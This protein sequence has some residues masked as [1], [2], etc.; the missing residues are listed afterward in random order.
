MLYGDYSLE[1]TASGKLCVAAQTGPYGVVRS[2]ELISYLPLVD[3]TD[4][5]LKFARLKLDLPG[6]I[7]WSDS[8][9]GYPFV[10]DE[11][12]YGRLETEKN[13]EAA[14]EWAR[15][16]G[17]LGLTAGRP[18]RRGGD[19]PRIGGNPMG[20]EEDTVWR[21][22][23]ESF[24][25]S[26]TLRL[27]EAATNP[28]GVDVGAIDRLVD[29]A[30][31]GDE[32]PQFARGKAL[33][34]VARV[35]EM[36]VADGCRPTLRRR[37]DVIAQGWDF[38]NL[39]SAM[40]LQMLWLVTADSGRRCQRRECNRAITIENPAREEG[41]EYRQWERGLRP[42]RYATRRDRMYCSDSCKTMASRSR[43]KQNG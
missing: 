41:L 33:D 8:L 34:I 25:A 28:S 42:T 21:F 20:G 3:H 19:P 37:S 35:V 36:M 39:L 2:A 43:K 1:R 26:R 5:F 40:W 10:F 15:D 11:Y 6:R 7:S 4:L 18:P 29:P 12:D 16:N 27:Y 13:N 32:S 9:T 14:Q 22:V 31:F 30:P 24:V 23:V 38:K 17:V